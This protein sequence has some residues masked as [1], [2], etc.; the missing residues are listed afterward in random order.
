MS[1]AVRVTAGVVRPGSD[2]FGAAPWFIAGHEAPRSAR[3]ILLARRRPERR[4]AGQWELPGGK[5]EPGEAP[6]V[7]LARELREELG[8]E[9]EVGA[10]VV[11]NAH[12]YGPGLGSVVLMAYEARIVGG[13]YAPI[14]HDAL[15]WVEPGDL[16]RFDLADADVPIA[17][18]LASLARG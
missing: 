14:D 8:L 10:H 4:H 3:A 17:R 5:I 7:C 1:G 2:V 16:L 6:E 11:D 15:A 12:D 18:H 13:A 9:V